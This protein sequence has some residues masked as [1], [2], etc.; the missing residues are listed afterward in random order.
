MRLKLCLLFLFLA[1]S[2]IYVKGQNI[3][4]SKSSIFIS[5]KI[6]PEI[7][8]TALKILQEEVF[9]RSNLKLNTIQKNTTLPIITVALANEVSFL[10]QKPPQFSQT[11][12]LNEGFLVKQEKINGQEILWL[13]GS[14]SRGVLYAIGQFLKTATFSNKKISIEKGYQFESFPKYS[15]RGHQLGYRNTAN[16][17]DAWTVQQ[18]EQ[19]IRE[20]VIFG[21]N[22]IENIPLQD[23]KQSPHMK[24]PR[25][26]MNNKLSEICHN[27]GIDYWAWT[28]IE[29]IS[30]NEKFDK[31]IIRHSNF[32]KTCPY[33]DA[34]FFPCGDPGDNDIKNV[35]PFLQKLSEKLKE[36]HPK[37]TIWVSLQGLNDSQVDYFYEY[38]ANISPNWLAGVVTGPSSPDLAETRYRLPAKYMHRH[39]PD[40]TH[41]V[42]C[43]YPTKNWDQAFALT[44]G[45]EV[46]NPQPYYYAKIHNRFAPFTDGFLAYS[47]GVHDDIN[48]TIWSQLAWDHTK[49]VDDILKEYARFFF[50]QNV[51]SEVSNGI[52]ALEHNWVGPVEENGG[53]ETTFEFWKNLELK[54]PQLATNWRWQLLVMRA[55]YDTWIKR[56]KIYEQNLEKEANII[57]L[58]AKNIGA[59]T[60]MDQALRLVNKPDYEPFEPEI[61]KKISDYC[62]AL[63]KSIGL[64]TSVKK[65]QASGAER[66]AITRL[67]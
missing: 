12:N 46:T 56:R 19:Y 9:K 26:E 10:G 42:R 20:L 5:D 13:V 36:S 66:G 18:Y 47:D 44:Q 8:E 64:Q 63:F 54:N 62:E 55:Y 60:A 43:Q 15:I 11:E 51:A 29:D 39:Y 14:D 30:T 65:Y 25:G 34:L 22:C 21:A 27:Y 50:G 33:I 32:Y 40:I 58:N 28:P 49:N 41:T 48:K 4:F 67:Y 6:K 45:R 52:L 31:E 61:K 23:D 57:L 37:A 17:W 35:L 53:I 3:D 16:S 2:L 59:D 1:T 24:V 38:L 7:K